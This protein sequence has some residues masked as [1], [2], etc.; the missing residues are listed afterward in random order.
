MF[1]GARGES[2]RWVEG[3]LGSF[4]SQDFVIWLKRVFFVRDGK[5]IRIMNHDQSKTVKK[6]TF[7]AL[8]DRNK[9]ASVEFQSSTPF[10]LLRKVR[11]FRPFWRWFWAKKVTEN[12]IKRTQSLTRQLGGGAGVFIGWPLCVCGS[13]QCFFFSSRGVTKKRIEV[14]A[15][16]CLWIKVA[17][18]C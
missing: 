13:C 3:G 9:R 15:E 12:V 14:R 10:Y 17:N 8:F 5:G 1:S 11:P 2:W 16:P 6:P 18:G 7:P 4:S